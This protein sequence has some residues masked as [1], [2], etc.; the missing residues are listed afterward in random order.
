MLIFEHEARRVLD[1]TPEA[2]FGIL[3]DPRRHAALA[4][5]GEVKA[6]RMHH[7][8]GVGVGSTFEA[9]EEIRLGRSTQKFT[10]V[11]TITEYD[12]PRVISWTTM[13]PNRPRPRRIQWW[14]VLEPTGAGTRVTERVEVDLGVVP[15]LLMRLPYGKLRG[16]AVRAGMAKTLDNLERTLSRAPEAGDGR[17]R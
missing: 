4:G 9:D 2:V 12:P 3:A 15:N 11:S 14:F 7:P 1:A 5:S 17:R 16:P 10:A 8:D 6:V 13:P